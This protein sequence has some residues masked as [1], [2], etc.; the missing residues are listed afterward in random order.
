EVGLCEVGD[1]GGPRAGC[2]TGVQGRNC[3]TAAFADSRG[4]SDRGSFAPAPSSR[5]TRESPA[6]PDPEG[7]ADFAQ[8]HHG[9]QKN[10]FQRLLKN[11][12][13]AEP[14]NKPATTDPKSPGSPA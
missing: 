7:L 1:S 9:R 5:T 4:L 11:K 10:K 8:P 14:V 6:Q 12:L 2:W 3:L 13:H